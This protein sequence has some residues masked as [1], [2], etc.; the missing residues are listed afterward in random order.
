MNDIWYMVTLIDNYMKYVW[1]LFMKENSNL[2]SK[3]K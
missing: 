1:I 2:F 3:F